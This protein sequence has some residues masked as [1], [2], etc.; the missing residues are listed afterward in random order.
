MSFIRPTLIIVG[1][2]LLEWTWSAPA[3]AAPSKDVPDPAWA[4]RYLL[5]YRA[6]TGGV[7]TDTDTTTQALRNGM[8]GDHFSQ[9][10]SK[11]DRRLKNALGPAAEAYRIQDGGTRPRRYALTLS[12]DAVRFVTDVTFKEEKQ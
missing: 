8:D 2:L 10:K 1:S 3:L 9:R 7:M 11:L 5:E 4:A 12:A 6:I